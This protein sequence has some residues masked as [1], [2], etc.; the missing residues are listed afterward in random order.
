MR[1][2]RL[3]VNADR[4]QIDQTAA[5]QVFKQRQVA[6][7][8]E[9]GEV[10]QRRLLG[11]ADD[12]VIRRVRAPDVAITSGM[13]NEPPISISSPRETRT[14]P[15][16]ANV[17]SVINTAAAQLLTTAAASQPASSRNI[18]SSPD[19]RFPRRPV[20]KSYSRLQ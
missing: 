14:S 13:R 9:A 1:D 12:A 16:S 18:A 3:V 7:A 20:C 2:C 15:P 5:S 19:P 8:S 4:V 10:F 6:I 11:E 17:L